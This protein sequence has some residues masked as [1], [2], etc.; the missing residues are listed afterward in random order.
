M[1]SLN[2]LNALISNFYNSLWWI[3]ADPAALEAEGSLE[4]ALN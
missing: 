1:I 3:F 4:T 2:Q